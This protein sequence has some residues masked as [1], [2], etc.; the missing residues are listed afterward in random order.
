MIMGGIRCPLGNHCHVPSTNHKFEDTFPPFPQVSICY[1]PW[2]GSFRTVSSAISRYF[3]TLSTDHPLVP[4]SSSSKDSEFVTRLAALSDAER[5]EM[6]VLEV[7]CD[8]NLEPR[9]DEEI[10]LPL[11]GGAI[12]KTRSNPQESQGSF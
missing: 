3:E 9:D 11:K 4:A 2:R 12:W 6:Q 7:R 10:V 1:F 8:A 5:R